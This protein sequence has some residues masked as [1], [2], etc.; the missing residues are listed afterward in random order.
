M[1]ALDPEHA[2]VRGTPFYQQAFALEAGV[3]ALGLVASNGIAVTPGI[4]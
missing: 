3:N 2:G 4:R 1:D